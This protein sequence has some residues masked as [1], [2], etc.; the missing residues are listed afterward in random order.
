MAARKGIWDAHVKKAMATQYII[1]PRMG[2]ETALLYVMSPMNSKDIESYEKT[3]YTD[4]NAVQERCTAKSTIY[5]A[6]LLAGLVCKAV[7]DIVTDNPFTRTTQWD[8]GKNQLMSWNN[9]KEICE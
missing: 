5:T 1:D 6:N 3:L 8:I 7:K 9:R 2:A 4:D